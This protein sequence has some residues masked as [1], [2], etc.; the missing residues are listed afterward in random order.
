MLGFLRT[1]ALLHVARSYPDPRM[2][3]GQS[4]IQPLL[5]VQLQQL[6]DYI[7]GFGRDM[8]PGSFGVDVVLCVGD[9]MQQCALAT[10]RERMY[11][12]DSKGW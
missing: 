11:F 7:L 1:L 4:R 6:G 8:W 9:L 5:R 2:S 12:S 10:R 3:Q